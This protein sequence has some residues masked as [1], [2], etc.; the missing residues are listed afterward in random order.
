MTCSTARSHARA[1][2]RRERTCGSRTYLWRPLELGLECAVDIAVPDECEPD[3][4]GGGENDRGGDDGGADTRAGGA[5][6]CC[7]GGEAGVTGVICCGCCVTGPLP[8]DRWPGATNTPCGV[9]EP[10]PPGLIGLEIEPS[11]RGTVRCMLSSLNTRW[12]P[13][14]KRKVRIPVFGG[15]TT[16]SP[17]ATTGGVGG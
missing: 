10:F 2:P 17:F 15:V 4:D 14:S 7:A 12:R 8:T 5:E 11:T 1:D 3:E 6:V 9:S 16:G 13:S